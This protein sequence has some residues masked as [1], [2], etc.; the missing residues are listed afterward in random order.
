MTAMVV[1]AIDQDAAHAHLAHSPRF[2]RRPYCSSSLRTKL[3]RAATKDWQSGVCS[4]LGVTNG[5][6][7]GSSDQARSRSPISALENARCSV[8]M[9]MS[10][11]RNDPGA[12]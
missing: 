1:G 10:R 8:S 4:A 3:Q 5:R 12:S 7:S 11:T 9:T 6:G 2:I